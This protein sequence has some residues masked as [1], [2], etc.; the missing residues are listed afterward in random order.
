M[1]R[2]S[3]RH[4]VRWESLTTTRRRTPIQTQS[5]ISSRCVF[6][7]TS[8]AWTRHGYLKMFYARVS[9]HDLRQPRPAE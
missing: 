4:G 5:H 6:S 8:S 3:Y 2:A 1:K 7:L 9:I